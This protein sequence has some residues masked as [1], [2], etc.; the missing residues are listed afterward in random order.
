[1]SIM[2][3]LLC[4]NLANLVTAKMTY[5]QSCQLSR[6]PARKPALHAMPHDPPHENIRNKN[7]KVTK[8]NVL[9]PNSLH[10]QPFDINFG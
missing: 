1:M 4:V 10:C 2:R 8:V 7:G 6:R 3:Q 5:L 9:E